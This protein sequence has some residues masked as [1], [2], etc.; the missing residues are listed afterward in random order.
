M[1]GMRR[2]IGVAAAL[3]VVAASACGAG[4]DDESAE[5]RTDDTVTETTAGS[6]ADFGALEAV[7]GPGEYT[8]DAS[9]Q[10]LDNG[11]LNIG[12]ANDRE[13][14]VR[15]GLNK[16]VWDSS[17][18]FAEW[19]NEQGGIGG[20]EI[21]VVDLSAELFNVEAAMTT[22][23]TDVFAMV[24]GGFVQDELQFSGNE[25]SD[26]HRCGMID[27][28]AFTVSPAKTGSNGMVQ[29]LPTTPAIEVNSPIRAFAEAF[30]DQAESAVVVHGDIPSMSD[31][32]TKRVAALE[33]VGVEVLGE[34]S[35]PFAGITDWG[36]YAQRVMESGATMIS[37]IG[38]PAN[39]ANL[40]ARLDDLGWEGRALL[41]TNAYDPLLFSLGD[42]A[43]E[44][45]VVRILVR[46][47]EEASEWPA[48][49]QYVD[50]LE[51]Y[52][53]DH[54]TSPL[55]VASISA[56]LL[57]ATAADA[58]AEANDGVLDRSCIIEQAAAQSDWTGG[59]LHA[60][61]DPALSEDVEPTTCVMLLQVV[62][63]GFERLV[64]ELGDELDDGEGFYCP[65]DARTQV[66]EFEGMGEID[67]SR[68]V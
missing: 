50:T 52:V 29:P 30:P 58:C 56:W 13:S 4:G 32:R 38:E 46:P 42:E 14:D 3:V 49:Q 34:I 51:E 66:P 6:G 17:V 68:P 48:V 16:E 37:W 12:V 23:C 44:G 60:P 55:G 25:G 43:P 15:P 8:V 1:S 28:P 26:F 33:D 31:T 7:C 9:E 54:K 65:E 24:G 57:F 64:P 39:A 67:P 59:G 5:E 35:Y 53:P 22:A 20:I 61:M 40:L 19:C 18:A 27:I 36:P 62:D 45:S 41:D 11:Q 21:N 63:G 2:I 47:L 10:G